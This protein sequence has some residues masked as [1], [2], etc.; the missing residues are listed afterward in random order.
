MG[1]SLSAYIRP[2]D[3]CPIYQRL[4]CFAILKS[5]IA[6]CVVPD[7]DTRLLDAFG[8]VAWET[9]ALCLGGF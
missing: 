1:S 7:L 4:Q 9:C 6:A 5:I 2:T 8:T 3:T